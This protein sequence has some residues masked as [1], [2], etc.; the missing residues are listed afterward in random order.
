MGEGGK[1]LV[2]SCGWWSERREPQPKRDAQGA[3]KQREGNLGQMP[4]RR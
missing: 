4:M 1:G 3:H 2:E